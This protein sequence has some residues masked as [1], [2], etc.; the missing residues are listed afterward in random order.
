MR[1]YLT[2]LAIYFTTSAQAQS[3]WLL[4]GTYTNKG[5]NNLSPPADSTGSQGIYVY[6]FDASTGHATYLSHTEGITNP[7]YL[8]IAPDKE[9]VYAATDTRTQTDGSI[10]AFRLDKT[11]GRLE[12]INKQPSGGANPV[13][14]AV[15]RSGRWVALANYT[16]GSLS[17][18]PVGGGG[19]LLP[20]AQNFRHTGH[21][22]NATRQEKSHVHSVVFSPDNRSLYAQDLGEDSIHI[23]QFNSA[24]PQPLQS[25]EKI[26]TTPGSG[27]RHL[28]FHPNGRYAYLVEELGGSVDSYQYLPGTGHLQLKQHIAAHADTAKGPFRSADIHVSADGRFLYVTNREGESNIAIFSIDEDKGTLRTIG[29]TQTLGMEPR[30]FTLD[31][32]GGYLLVANQDSN[33]IIIFKVNKTTG[34][35]QPTGERIKIPSPSCLKMVQ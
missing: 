13:Y 18:F 19:A 26:A 3:S 34:L 28:V 33:E 15:H 21:S 25:T 31:P 4:I 2:L 14:V 1:I 8:E 27:P 30:N 22:I 23:F 6:K 20:Y 9:H 32:T 17:V 16:G 35:L 7:S 11:K 29:Y 5:T 24:T 10:N 12:F